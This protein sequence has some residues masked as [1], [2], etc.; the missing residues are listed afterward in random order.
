MRVF[1]FYTH[2]MHKV[3]I[4]CYKVCNRL[5]STSFVCNH[6]YSVLVQAFVWL[7]Y[8]FFLFW[9]DT[10]TGRG[11]AYRGTEDISL[12]IINPNI[13]ICVCVCV[14]ILSLTCRK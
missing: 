7:K 1:V 4:I 10:K 12:V 8:K 13:Y 11:V 2:L 9:H 14:C 5:S 3:Y 6:V